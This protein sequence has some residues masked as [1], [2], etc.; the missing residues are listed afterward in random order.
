[1]VDLILASRYRLRAVN[2]RM[3]RDGRMPSN[4]VSSTQRFDTA[5]RVMPCFPAMW[6][7][8]EPE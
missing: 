3:A 7:I 6:V 2:E 8:E 1:L 5:A 4:S